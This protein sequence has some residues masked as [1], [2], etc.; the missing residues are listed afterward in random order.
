MKL[1]PSTV[2]LFSKLRKARG[3]HSGTM[4]LPQ[5]MRSTLSL[6]ISQ[7]NSSPKRL[8]SYCKEINATD[9]KVAQSIEFIRV[10][11]LNKGCEVIGERFS[12]SYYCLIST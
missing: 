11:Q 7:L 4:R 3:R 2:W 6:A 10:P 12:C 9:G 1:G 5:M 8:L